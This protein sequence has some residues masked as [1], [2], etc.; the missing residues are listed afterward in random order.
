MVNFA[1]LWVGRVYGTNTGNL[2]M[3]LN[4]SDGEVTGVLR[5][6][7]SAFGLTVYRLSGSYDEQMCLHGD[8]IHVPEGVDAGPIDVTATLTE[9]G[10]LRGEWWSNTQIREEVKA[11]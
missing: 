2:F 9:Q 8:V 3:E 1:K 5:V 11:V 7:D 4:A 6:M 10:N